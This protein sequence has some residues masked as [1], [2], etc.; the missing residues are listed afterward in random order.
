MQFTLRIKISSVYFR[1]FEDFDLL[2]I[3]NIDIWIQSRDLKRTASKSFQNFQYNPSIIAHVRSYFPWQYLP[4]T[5]MSP[6][7]ET[8]SK[9]GASPDTS[10]RYLPELVRFTLFKT[11]ELS[12]DSSLWMQIRDYKLL[13]PIERDA[14]PARCT[15]QW[16]NQILSDSNEKLLAVRDIQ[17][18]LCF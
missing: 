16:T 14:E 7:S 6:W 12:V 5:V 4:T 8:V 2:F 13:R 10:H 18:A 15:T 1:L 9:A 11:T 3:D 17:S